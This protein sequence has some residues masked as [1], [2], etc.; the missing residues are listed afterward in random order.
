MPPGTGG[1]LADKV[2]G[3]FD[4]GNRRAG[5]GLIAVSGGSTPA[6]FFA[7]PVDTDI[8]WDKVTITLVDERFV[9][10][11]L[12]TLQPPAGG[13]NL[14]QNNGQGGDVPAALPGSRQRRGRRK[15]LRHAARPVDRQW[16]FDVV[17]LGMGR[18]RPHGLVLPRRRQPGNAARSQDSARI[19]L[20]MDAEGAG[21]PRLTFTGSIVDAG[22][23][24]CTSKARTRKT[25]LRR[26]EVAGDEADMP[27]R[28]VRRGRLARRGIYWAP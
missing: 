3:R 28:A 22:F 2:A 25:V 14:L 16:P 20:P 11:D 8:D 24:R 5:T 27:I 19:V 6:K 10:A 23:S 26:R 18:R 7:G 9:P 1:N 12:A 21:E 4:Q 15:A 17:M 13:G